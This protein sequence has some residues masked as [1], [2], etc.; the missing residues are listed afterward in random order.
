MTTTGTGSRSRGSSPSIGCPLSTAHS[1]TRTS[2]THPTSKREPSTEDLQAF[3]RG[4]FLTGRP[5]LPR[6]SAAAAPQGKKSYLNVSLAAGPPQT[7][8]RKFYLRLPWLRRAA[9]SCLHVRVD[10]RIFLPQSPSAVFY[11][12]ARRHSRFRVRA[13][14]CAPLTHGY[15]SY[16]FNSKTVR[17]RPLNE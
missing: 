17:G 9:A 14:R 4:G 16:R 12:R 5:F 10:P 3:G 13:C 6:A 11:L 2:R 7:V 1:R 8:L 15:P